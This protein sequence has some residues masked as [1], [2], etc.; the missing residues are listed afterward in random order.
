[1]KA[2]LQDKDDERRYLSRKLVEFKPNWEGYEEHG[3][4]M[5]MFIN[6]PSGSEVVLCVFL[7]VRY[8]KCCKDFVYFRLMLAKTIF[9]PFQATKYMDNLAKSQHL[10]YKIS[11]LKRHKEVTSFYPRRFCNKQ[12][13]DTVWVTKCT[14]YNEKWVI[15]LCIFNDDLVLTHIRI[16]LY[17]TVIRKGQMFSFETHD[18]YSISKGN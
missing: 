1:M 14:K 18:F 17:N 8:R 13:I 10:Y 2:V 7:S 3:I 16:Q 15:V 6:I 12:R 4:M 11:S 5:T 9:W